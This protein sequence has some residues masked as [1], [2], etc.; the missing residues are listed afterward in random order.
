MKPLLQTLLFTILVPGIV[1]G[2]VPWL[3]RRPSHPV[4]AAV[5]SAGTVLIAIGAAIY[6]HTAF[7]GFARRGR[8]TPAPIAPTKELVVSGLHRYVRNPMY[9]GVLLIVLGQ[10]ALFDS[11]TVL[12]YAV[13]LWAAFHLF[14]LLYEEPTLHKQFGPEYDAY[15]HRV[16]RWLPKF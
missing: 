16:P 11:R 6:L 7:W 1:A 3:L 14:V 13:F 2:Y 12:L 9:I 10:A 4:S 5:L 8:G 15:K